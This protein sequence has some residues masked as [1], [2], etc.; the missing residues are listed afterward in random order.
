MDWTTTDQPAYQPRSLWK[1]EQI[2]DLPCIRNAALPA[3]QPGGTRS[4]SADDCTE[5]L[6]A[7]LRA[8]AP[9]PDARRA[10]LEAM[11]PLD[12]PQAA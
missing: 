2:P 1:S 3:P 4:V 9:F 11:G 6:Q 8:V 10:V 12:P 5:V 7:V